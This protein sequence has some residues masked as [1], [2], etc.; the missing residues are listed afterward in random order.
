MERAERTALRR[1]AHRVHLQAVMFAAVGTA[2]AIAV[3]LAV[4]PYSP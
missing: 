4:R 2:V 1:Q 3:R